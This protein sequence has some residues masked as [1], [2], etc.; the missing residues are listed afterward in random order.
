MAVANADNA[1]R[2]VAISVP[3]HANNLLAVVK[4]LAAVD[5]GQGSELPLGKANS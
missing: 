4:V 3:R 2:A 5:G 1:I